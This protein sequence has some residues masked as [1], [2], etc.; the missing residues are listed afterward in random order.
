[1]AGPKLS[2]VMIAHCGLAEVR[3]TGL[4]LVIFLVLG[5]EQMQLTWG[6]P[7]LCLVVYSILLDDVCHQGSFFFNKLLW[8]LRTTSLEPIPL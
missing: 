3:M 4:G 8:A 5:E 2:Q 7:V 1:M 6:V